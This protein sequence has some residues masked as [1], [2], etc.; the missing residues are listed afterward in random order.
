MCQTHFY[1]LGITKSLGG[2]EVVFSIALNDGAP[3]KAIEVVLGSKGGGL[4]QRR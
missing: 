3:F 2:E 1:Q 4:N